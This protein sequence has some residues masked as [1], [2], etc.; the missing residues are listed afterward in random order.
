MCM[1]LRDQF[2]CSIESNLVYWFVKV[3]VALVARFI[4]GLGLIPTH[5][6]H[7]TIAVYHVHIMNVTF[8][9]MCFLFYA[10]SN[11]YAYCYLFC[12]CEIFIK[13]FSSCSNSLH[14]PI[15]FGEVWSFFMVFYKSCMFKF[16]LDV[17]NF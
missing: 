5:A 13:M 10:S 11:F 7:L 2:L 1:H 6:Y 12:K 16:F 8:L 9:C 3:C 15:V 14:I 17:W 4:L